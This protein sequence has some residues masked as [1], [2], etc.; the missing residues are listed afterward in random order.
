MVAVAAAFKYKEKEN[1]ITGSKVLEQIVKDVNV[2]NHCWLMKGSA[3]IWG[4]LIPAIIL[5]L[6][7]FYL[8]AQGGGAIKMSAG[9]QIDAKIRN[10]MIK[11]RGL[12]IGLFFKVLIKIIF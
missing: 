9:L 11:K 2:S 6:I 5:L 1:K 10:K 4:F 12:Q 8:A 7:G 3:Y